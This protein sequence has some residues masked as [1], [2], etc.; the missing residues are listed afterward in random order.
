MLGV[1]PSEQSLGA[2]LTANEFVEAFHNALF[3]SMIRVVLGRT[4]KLLPQSKYVNTCG[5]VHNF[6]DY[7]ISQAYEENV[8][9]QKSLI[10]ALLVQTEDQNFI[11][12]QVIQAMMA[13]Q[14][15]TSELITN[16]LFLLAR[17]PRYWEQLRLE[18]L[19]K[20][21]D[22]L[23]METLMSSK[24]IENILHESKCRIRVLV[25]GIDWT[26]T[27]LPILPSYRLEF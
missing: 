17:H 5:K 26:K 23:S 7:Y 24:L 2:P 12:S 16:S 8:P 22:D 11:R 9:K 21:E 15:T 3:Y 6:I 25:Y 20:A 13:A 4:W 19:D 10:R 1:D 18:F 14:D 27:E